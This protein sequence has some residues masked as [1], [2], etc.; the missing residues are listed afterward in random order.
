MLPQAYCQKFTQGSAEVSMRSL[1][2]P[3]KSLAG[4]ADSVE[5]AGA[6]CACAAGICAKYIVAPISKKAAARK[7][8]F[9][10]FA[11][12]Q[13]CRT[14]FLLQNQHETLQDLAASM[15]LRDDMDIPGPKIRT[16]GTHCCVAVHQT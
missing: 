6:A 10:S 12:G 9:I 8:R 4:L 13:N 16:W 11:S 2:N 15:R 5:A 1:S 3:G 7:G 14:T